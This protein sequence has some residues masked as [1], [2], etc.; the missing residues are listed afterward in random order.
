MATIRGTDN[1]DTLLGT[2]GDDTFEGL[3][4]ITD[5]FRGSKGSDT[6]YGHSP[7]QTDNLTL[8]AN[9]V[10]YDTE[11]GPSGVTVNLATGLGTDSY[12]NAE[13]YFDI[14]EVAGTKNSD[15]IIGA[16]S[17][18]IIRPFAGNDSLDGGGGFDEVHYANDPDLLGIVAN[19]GQGTVQKK[20]A[21]GVT[22]TD[23]ISNFEAIRGSMADDI[24]M[25]SSGNDRFR[26]MKGADVI[27]GGDGI[28]TVDYLR[29]ANASDGR[30]GI[31]A[32]LA[33]GTVRDG[34]GT[35]DQVSN[36]ENVRGTAYADSIVGDAKDNVL[37]GNGGNDVID[38]GAGTDTAEY[39]GNRNDYSI[40]R[41][42]NGSLTVRDLRA[43]NAE[44]T[45]TLY[46][47][48]RLTFA[49]ATID[50][51]LFPIPEP[52]EPPPAPPPAA[53]AP[54]E[55]ATAID[56]IVPGLSSPA[57]DA[58]K[59]ELAAGEITFEQLVQGLI[60]EAQTTTV[61]ALVMANLLGGTAP[62]Q[63]HLAALTVF[64]QEQ[65]EAYLER[66]VSNPALGPYEALGYGFSSTAEFATR[67]GALVAESFVLSA[68]QE[69]FGRQATPAQSG[70]FDSQMSYFQQIYRAAGLTPEDSL[71]KAKG[72]IIGQMMG[73]AVLDEP[74]LHGFDDAANGFLAKAATGQ[75]G[76]G[77]PLEL[78]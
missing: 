76:Y 40:S 22:F 42:Q 62:T 23:A 51:S 65:F 35:I 54:E 44:G 4:G 39:L 61:P 14:S 30:N 31:D 29:D 41:N 1:D 17:D 49:D 3:G 78:L 64:A 28:D 26:G 58:L 71:T 66:G 6:Y 47:I 15:V 11:T 24:L 32:N 27:D 77:Q 48:E 67:Y 2:D 20:Y 55:I 13:R 50:T 8:Y 74:E 45:D 5:L 10:W 68:Y 53:P 46:G 38:G 59:A 60:E 69:V 21:G 9:A 33:S 34:F 72:A 56:A 37:R 12:G 19:L 70:H 18:N 75:G 63:E 25:G 57:I 43:G 73:H 52:S 16:A 36:V 7:G